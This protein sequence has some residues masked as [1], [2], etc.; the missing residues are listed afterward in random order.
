MLKTYTRLAFLAISVSVIPTVAIA[1]D[2]NQDSQAITEET[3]AQLMTAG[4]QANAALEALMA[5]R[6][7]ATAPAPGPAHVPLGSVP[8]AL[9]QSITMTWNGASDE[10][11][12]QIADAVGYKFVE[13]GTAPT[14]PAIVTMVMNGE[15]AIWALQDLGVRIRDT[16]TVSVNPN[17]HEIDYSFHLAQGGIA[18][19]VTGSG[20]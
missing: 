16:A 20:L 15:P 13:S 14:R 8:A 12:R 19:G 7:T 9:A 4:N 11:A 17:V 3:E 6:A 2:P 18:G 5:D 10:L 1:D